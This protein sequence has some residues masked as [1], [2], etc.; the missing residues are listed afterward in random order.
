MRMQNNYVVGTIFTWR[1]DDV[2]V[3]C[4]H[5]VTHWLPL[6]GAPCAAS[7]KILFM[8][9]GCAVARRDGTN[10]SYFFCPCSCRLCTNN[11]QRNYPQDLCSS[12][13]AV[14]APSSNCLYQ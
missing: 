5:L 12:I 11:I 7:L 13:L 8:L 9:Q 4:W 1:D 10:R 3:L 6:R 14:Q 2:V